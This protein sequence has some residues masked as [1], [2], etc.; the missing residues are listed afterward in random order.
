MKGIAFILNH[1]QS[2]LGKQQIFIKVVFFK[3]KNLL[4]DL[5]ETEK[6]T[7]QRTPWGC[8]QQHPECGKLY[9]QMTPFLQ[10]RNY[11]KQTKRNHRLRDVKAKCNAKRKKEGHLKYIP[12]VVYSLSFDIDLNKLT[13]KIYY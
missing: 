8:N 12:N 10:S 2:S 6:A 7:C 11:K 9:R 5:Q 4:Y 3:N 13:T 1:P